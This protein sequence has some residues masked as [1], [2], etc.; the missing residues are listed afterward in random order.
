MTLY[1]LV[2]Y[3]LMSCP[4]LAI[5]CLPLYFVAAYNVISSY[6]RHYVTQHIQSYHMVQS[7]FSV[8]SLGYNFVIDSVLFHFILVYALTL[9]STV[10]YYTVWVVSDLLVL[11]GIMV[12][13]CYDIICIYIYKYMI[14]NMCV[15]ICTYTYYVQ[16]MV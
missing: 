9:C 15:F 13:L 8:F 12:M 16:I 11:C 5:Y 3:E 4:M 1:Y 6:F 2:F 10:V 14:Y 7:Y